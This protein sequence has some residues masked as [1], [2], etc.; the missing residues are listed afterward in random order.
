MSAG[1]R[2][3]SARPPLP[4]TPG[5]RLSV[6]LLRS[7]AFGWVLVCRDDPGLLASTKQ[8]TSPGQ[9]ARARSREREREK[10]RKIERERERERKREREKERKMERE[11]DVGLT[12]EELVANDSEEEDEEEEEEER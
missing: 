10:E 6:S 12:G 4:R 5:F 2:P 11:R 8:R 3:R 1:G 9:R 7:S